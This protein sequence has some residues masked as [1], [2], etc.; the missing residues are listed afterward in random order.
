MNTR[1]SLARTSAAVVVQNHMLQVTALLAMDAPV[2]NDSEVLRDEKL[3]I[4]RAI[5]PL[6]PAE[7]VRGQYQGYREEQDVDKKSKVETF[8]ALR[9]H[10]DSWRWSEVPI[11][12]RAGKHLPVT[13]T[14]VVVDLKRPPQTIFDPFTCQECNYLR[15]RLS[16]NVLISLGARAKQV[17]E[18]M[19]GE[20]VELVAQHKSAEEMTAYE[21]L[22]GDASRGDSSLFTR[23]DV[24]EAAWRIVEPVLGDVAP[25]HEYEPRSWGPSEADRLFEGQGGWRNPV[26]FSPTS[27]S[28]QDRTDC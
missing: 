8:A 21:R 6:D 17:G 18:A 25:P 7:A 1:T 4:F 27:K 13:V 19:L 2:H 22:L 9:L 26:E 23:E 20:Q 24:V 16:P 28:P 3:R 15:F 14:E 10:I 11:Y 12:I 5:R